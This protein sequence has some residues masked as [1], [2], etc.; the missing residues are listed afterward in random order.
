MNRFDTAQK[1]VG[2]T[3]LLFFYSTLT[4]AHH[5]ATCRLKNIALYAWTRLTLLVIQVWYHIVF[6]MDHLHIVGLYPVPHFIFRQH[7]RFLRQPKVQ[8]LVPQDA[9]FHT[10]LLELN[11]RLLLVF[12]L[13]FLNPSK[14]MNCIIP[15]LCTADKFSSPKFYLQ[16]VSLLNLQMEKFEISDP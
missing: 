5:L 15:C 9:F 3:C 16:S 2:Y 10:N 8:S 6:R 12:G 13:L 1:N 7:P 4:W 14:Q 11:N